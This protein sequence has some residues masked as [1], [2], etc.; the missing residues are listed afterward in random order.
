MFNAGV[1]ADDS[2]GAADSIRDGRRKLISPTPTP[3]SFAS[4]ALEIDAK[5]DDRLGDFG[6]LIESLIP[7]FLIIPSLSNSTAMR[8]TFNSIGTGFLGIDL[9]DAA[10][11]GEWLGEGYWEEGDPEGLGEGT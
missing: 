7:L 1:I 11:L 10:G 9:M 4:K 5:V 8:S 2:T 3:S 6:G